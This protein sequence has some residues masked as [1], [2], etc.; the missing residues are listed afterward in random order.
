LTYCT[1]QNFLK[2]SKLILDPPVVLLANLAIIISIQGA[3]LMSDPINVSDA[4]LTGIPARAC[5]L[6]GQGIQASIV[7]QTL[8][9]TEG[10]ISQL[11]SEDVFRHKVVEARYVALQKHNSRDAKY[12]ELEDDLLERLKATLPMVFA[13]MQLAKILQTINAAK[14]R[15][16]NETGSITQHNMV[17]NLTLP[18]AIVERF[19]VL[20]DS[21]NQILEA[22]AQKLVTIQSGTLLSRIQKQKEGNGNEISN[23]S[24]TPAI[25]VEIPASPGGT[26][27]P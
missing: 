26:G 16:T 7:A 17:V 1:S 22:G 21:N 2:F 6:L 13:P 18:T 8:G 15:G 19:Q 25:G 12:D 3:N 9:V 5:E 10:Y 11:L 27:T 4:S 20:K 23:Q 14:R 24:G